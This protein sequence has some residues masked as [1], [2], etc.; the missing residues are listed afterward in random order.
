MPSEKTTKV[1]DQLVENLPSQSG[2]TIAITGCTSGMG[3]IFAQMVAA[4]GAHVIL[5]NRPSARAE[6][7]LKAVQENGDAEHVDCDLT[8]FT[9]VREA[10]EV[11][12]ENFDDGLDIL[13]NNAGVMGLPRQFTED[14]FD[15]QI[16]VNY[17]SH[18]LL[19]HEVWPAL[20]KAGRLRGEARVVNHSSGARN[21]PK[22]P[23]EDGYFY[24]G[25]HIP[26]DRWPGM[27]KWVRYQ[28]SKLA[29]LLFTYGLQEHAD[30]LPNNCVKALCAHPGPA[31]SGLQ[32]KVGRSQKGTILDRYILKSTLKIAQ[33][34]E[35]GTAGLIRA[36]FDPDAPS[37]GFYGPDAQNRVGS[38]VL[39]PAERDRNAQ[40]LLWQGSL[41]A[42]G[43]T[44][45]FDGIHT[46]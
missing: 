33:S 14:G 29:N 4:K 26:K 7:A 35:D 24:K 23:L 45:F 8:R 34:P 30:Q 40:S 27:Q 10:A 15:I 17:L 11:L 42:I 21:N 12:I 43:L 25:D 13:V 2:K 37:G 28:Q 6:T 20:K 18:F 41:K 22:R 31:D 5:L 32:S 38:A 46:E 39:L 44:D 16:Q 1:F 19:T 36:S 3:F 9:S